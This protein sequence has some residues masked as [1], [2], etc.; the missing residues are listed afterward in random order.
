MLFWNAF[1]SAAAVAQAFLLGRRFGAAAGILAGTF[2]VVSP[3]DV[4]AAHYAAGD[5]AASFFALLTVYLAVRIA[6]TGGVRH[7]LLGALATAAA[8][9]SKYNGAEAGVALALAHLVRYP[10]RAIVSGAALRRAGAAA[11]AL[12][13]GVVLTS[14]AMLVNP[15]W[16]IASI[17]DFLAW[18]A[19]YGLKEAEVRMTLVERFL[20]S[21]RNNGLLVIRATSLFTLAG[22]AAALVLARPRKLVWVV[23]ALPLAH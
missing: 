16:T 21:L 6:E 14:P 19:A 10:G 22:V 9:S 13:L 1:L 12:A 17:R 3:L 11:A 8:F 4:A 2:A 7:Y 20:W 15:G 23:A 5:T 18:V